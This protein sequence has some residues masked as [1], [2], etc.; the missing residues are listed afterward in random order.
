MKR[1]SYRQI[2]LL[3]R[4]ILSEKEL[5]HIL[6]H[7]REQTSTTLEFLIHIVRPKSLESLEK[8]LK[9]LPEF[10]Y[11]FCHFTHIR[12]MPF[13]I[14]SGTF[15]LKVS[16]STFDV[17]ES[18]NLLY[19]RRYV[20]KHL[21]A[22]IGQV[23]DYNGGLFEKQQQHFE[24]IRMHLGGKIRHFDIFAEK[25]FYAIHPV[26]RRLFLSLL[27]AEDLFSS[28]SDL[29]QEKTTPA[30]SLC[31]KNVKITRM[32]SPSNLLK[33]SNIEL[34]SQKLAGQV[35]LNLGGL[36]YYCLFCPRGMEIESFLKRELLYERKVQKLKTHLSRRRTTIA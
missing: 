18:I 24:M 5:P 31:R 16:S 25:V 19:A 12:S 28:F 6:I 23:R 30:I 22:V 10:L 14:E 34:E 26:E 33:L 21:E 9:R 20:L 13:P 35:L 7:F 32:D 2:Q 17:R 4:E 11:S 36:H 15:S 1:K 8:C 29:I 27:E 3:Q